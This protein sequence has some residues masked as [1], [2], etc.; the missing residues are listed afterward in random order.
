MASHPEDSIAFSDDRLI[1]ESWLSRT[2]FPTVLVADY[3]GVFSSLAASPASAVELATRLSLS[4]RATDSMLVLLAAL[5]MLRASHGYYRPTAEGRSFFLPN[6]PFYWGGV[7]KESMRFDSLAARIRDVMTDLSAEKDPFAEAAGGPGDGKWGSDWAAGALGEEKARAI[8]AFMHSHSISAAVR[9]ARSGLFSKARHLLDVAGGSG[10]Y[11]IELARGYPDLQCT[12]LELPAACI[13]ANSYIATAGVGSSVRTVA[14][15]MFRQP[16]PQGYDAVLLSNVL[17]DWS[18]DSC[19]GLAK[20]AHDALCA[21]GSIFVHEMLID[22]DG[23]GPR[24]AAAFSMLVTLGTRGRQLRLSEICRLLE[25]SGFVDI[26]RTPV[27]PL[28]DV[29]QGRKRA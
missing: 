19:A 23:N 28:Y 2:W 25:A 10:C 1:W 26:Q 24:T 13:A 14:S 11:A 22:E 4:Q 5:G 7:L 16:W 15:D 3:L 6:S 20:R 12:V 18:L 8:A 9:L 29:V 17:H 21:D 27:P